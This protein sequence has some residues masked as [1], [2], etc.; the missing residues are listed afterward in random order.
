MRPAPL[1]IWPCQHLDSPLTWPSRPFLCTL[2]RA[3]ARESGSRSVPI[4]FQPR[5]LPSRAYTAQAPVPARQ[6][7]RRAQVRSGRARLPP[8][9]RQS[10]MADGYSGIDEVIPMMEFRCGCHSHRTITQLMLVL[11]P[12]TQRGH[13]HVERIA[14]RKKA[15]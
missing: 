6:D 9:R 1:P 11:G 3:A 8:E 2:L 14:Y 10:G 7:P 4:M 5:R 15:H 12:W 13:P